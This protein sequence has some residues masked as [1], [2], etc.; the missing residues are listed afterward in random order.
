MDKKP[1]TALNPLWKDMKQDVRT[2]FLKFYFCSWCLEIILGRALSAGHYTN[3]KDKPKCKGY[4][5]VGIDCDSKGVM[6]DS[7]NIK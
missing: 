6:I 3:L 4:N 1:E 2:S 7:F 5:L